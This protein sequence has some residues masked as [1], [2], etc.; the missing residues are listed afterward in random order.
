MD[1]LLDAAIVLSGLGIILG[2]VAWASGGKRTALCCTASAALAVGLKSG[3]GG[4]ANAWLGVFAVLTMINF[5]TMKASVF[6]RQVLVLALG[7][8]AICGIV[9]SYLLRED[10][11]SFNLFLVFTVACASAVAVV[12]AVLVGRIIRRVGTARP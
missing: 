9:A 3:S 5:A 8:L 10:G 7:G 1:L 4:W 11:M 12:A 2:L 6:R